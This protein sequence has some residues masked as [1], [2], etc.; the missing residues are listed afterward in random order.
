MNRSGEIKLA[1]HKFLKGIP[2]YDNLHSLYR[3]NLLS[4]YF[5]NIIEVNLS[6]VQI[7]YLN[8]IHNIIPQQE[9]YEMSQNRPDWFLINPQI[10]SD[11]YELDWT[12]K[13]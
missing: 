12:I 8:S 9:G 4:H 6:Q 2:Y 10:I 13:Q 7:R 5:S 1:M 11:V 3:R